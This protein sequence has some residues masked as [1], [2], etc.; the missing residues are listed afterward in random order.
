VAGVDAGRAAT[1][2]KEGEMT[3]KQIEKWFEAE[4]E[5]LAARAERRGFELWCLD[6]DQWERESVQSL[7]KVAI[8]ASLNVCVGRG[9]TPLRALQNAIARA[10]RQTAG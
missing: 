3:S 4:R 8:V 9:N 10:K 1:E 5:K 7:W 6:R 2:N